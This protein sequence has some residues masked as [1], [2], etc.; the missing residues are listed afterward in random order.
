MSELRWLS[1]AAAAAE[2]VVVYVSCPQADSEALARL[3]IE[4]KAAACVNIV[5]TVRSLYRWQGAVEASEESMLIIKTRA[6]SLPR[7]AA[8]IDQHHPYDVPELIAMPICAGLPAYL[9]WIDDCIVN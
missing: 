9:N 8:L 3:F 6:A 2:Y 7:L 4:E 5:A 1:P